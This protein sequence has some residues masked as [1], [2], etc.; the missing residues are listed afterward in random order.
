MAEVFVSL[1]TVILLL[2]NSLGKCLLK[3]NFLLKNNANHW[4][5]GFYEIIKCQTREQRI[6][7]R[8][9]LQNG[10]ETGSSNISDRGLVS[11]PYKELKDLSERKVS[12]TLN[13]ISFGMDIE[14]L[15]EVSVVTRH[16]DPFHITLCLNPCIV[17]V[18]KC[19]DRSN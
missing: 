18:T 14:F 4:Q 19:P 6:E 13:K 17:S 5:V 10:I 11:R 9:R 15:K 2:D 8:D 3:E 12:N 16:T 1:D 7:C